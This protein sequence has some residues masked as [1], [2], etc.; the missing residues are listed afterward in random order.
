[1]NLSPEQQE[2]GRRNFFKA[3]A[4][5]P[6]LAALG[7]AAM[8][9]GPKKGGPVKAA[10]VGAGSEGKVLLNQCQKQWIDIRALCDINPLH[11]KTA[12]EGLEKKGLRRPTEYQDLKTMLEKEDL[13]AVL[14]ATPLRSHADVTV[15]CLEAGKHVLCEKMM[16]WDVPS[17]HRMAESAQKNKRLLE[18]GYQRF[19]NPTYH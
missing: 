1:M 10:L 17:C 12:A 8:M 9:K 16:A 2:I 14:I 6:A 3:V 13:E 11:S 19:Y 18:I 5:I 15:Q 7:G 4:G